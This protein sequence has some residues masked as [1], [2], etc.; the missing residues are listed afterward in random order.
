PARSRRRRR[1]DRPVSAALDEARDDRPL[2][3]PRRAPLA[4]RA[5]RGTG[6]RFGLLRPARALVVSGGRAAPRGGDRPRRGRLLSKTAPCLARCDRPCSGSRDVYQ[7]RGEMPIRN[8]AAALA[9]ALIAI[10]IGATGAG[11]ITNGQPDGDNH[12]YVG[13][14]VGVNF[15]DGLA[16]LCTGSLLDENSFLTAG[17]CTQG[18]DAIFVWFDQTL[19]QPISLATA[20]AVG[21]GMTNPDFC[22][23]CAKGLPGFARRDVGVVELVPIS[24]DI[25]T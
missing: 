5:G 9:A 13:V 4:P 20:D 8:S 10:L 19:T 6:V 14:M 11:A 3:A 1:D 22:E 17:H 25:P 21:S 23:G 24:D 2:G 18:A 15:T 7:G 16:W 12:P